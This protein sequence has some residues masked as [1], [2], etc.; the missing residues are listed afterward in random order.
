MPIQYNSKPLDDNKIN[1]ILEAANW[2]PTHKRTEP[3]RYK[4]FKGKKKEDLGEFLSKKY[5]ETSKKFSKFKE[6]KI[7]EKIF[8]SSVIILICMQRDPN[9]SIPKWEEIASVSMSVQNMWLMSSFLGIGSYWSSPY[10]INYI[11]EFIKLNQ[12][13]RCLGIY[14]LGNYSSQPPSRKP[15]SIEDKIQKFY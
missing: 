14:Y 6:I 1:Q 15:S 10:L 5:K 7:K 2:A 11:G 3:W 8:K 9:K 13:E 12:G 4:I